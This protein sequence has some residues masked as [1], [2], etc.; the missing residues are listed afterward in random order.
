MIVGCYAKGKMAFEA[1][2][3]LQRAGGNVTLVLLID[4]FVAI[5]GKR[6]LAWQSLSAIWRALIEPAND[7]PY[8]NKLGAFF[9]N[10]WCLLRWVLQQIPGGVK[11][12]IMQLASPVALPSP[13]DDKE[14]VP[15]ERATFSRFQRLTAVSFDPTPLDAPGALIRAEY[16]DEERLPGYDITNGWRHLFAGG[17]EVVQAKGDHVSIVSDENAVTFGQAG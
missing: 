6:G 14:G 17:L 1:A 11:Y 10:F 12:R 9:R 5:G 15:F 13:M 3:A 4:A 8:M 16:P 7:T 2:H